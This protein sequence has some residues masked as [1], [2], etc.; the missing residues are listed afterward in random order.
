[1]ETGERVRG[2]SSAVNAPLSV[3]SCPAEGSCISLC[4]EER[5]L[6]FFVRPADF[7]NIFVQ[8]PCC[9]MQIL[10]K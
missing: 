3:C 7:V 2:G 10:F 9:N 4:F 1:M 5:I 8:R 6:V